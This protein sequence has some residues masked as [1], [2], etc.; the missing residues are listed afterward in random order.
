MFDC[1]PKAYIVLDQDDHIVSIKRK[2]NE[3]FSVNDLTQ[4][5]RIQSFSGSK[6]GGNITAMHTNGVGYDIYK[7]KIKL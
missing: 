5:G 1:T 6:T 2:D 4:H 7:L 3:I